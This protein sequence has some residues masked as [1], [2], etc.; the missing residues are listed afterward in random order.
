MPELVGEVAR[1]RGE[2]EAADP[3]KEDAAEK[4]AQRRGRPEGHQGP[5]PHELPQPLTNQDYLGSVQRRAAGSF[6][7][8]HG[9]TRP[10][11]G[12]GRARRER[13]ATLIL[14]GLGMPAA[15]GLERQKGRATMLRW[16]AV[17]FVIAIVAAI[18]GFA[19]I[20]A[21]AAGV[22]K[23]LFVVFLVLAGISLLL[24]RRVVA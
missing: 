7:F 3:R 8:C 11:H 4:R 20:A 19:G 6:A 24:G 5:A 1:A 12:A 16:A 14:G 22:A 9:T 15:G 17:F 13:R 10:M 18:F 21:N 23:V 2:R